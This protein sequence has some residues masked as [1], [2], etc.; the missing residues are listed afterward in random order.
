MAGVTRPQVLGNGAERI[1]TVQARG[2]DDGADGGLALSH[3]H[4]AL[5]PTTRDR[6]GDKPKKQRFATYAIGYVHID[7]AEMSTAEGKLRLFVAIDRTSQFVFVRLV[8]SAGKMEAA[9]FLRDFIEAMPYRIHTVLTDNVLRS[10]E[11]RLARHQV[12]VR[13]HAPAVC[14]SS[15]SIQAAP[16]DPEELS[17]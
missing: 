12:S 2:V 9:Q 13:E 17:A 5:E 1:G 6:E 4:G 15:T 11:G 3:P 16:A 7:I 14:L 8:E 10:D